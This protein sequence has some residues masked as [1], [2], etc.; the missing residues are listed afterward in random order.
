M[1]AIILA[2]G[3]GKRLG[4]LT[5]GNTKCMIEV[6][7]VTLIQRMLEQLDSLTPTLSHIVLVIGYEGKK[8][9]DYIATLNIKIPIHYVENKDFATTNNIFSLALAKEY[10]VSEDTLLLESDLIFE[11]GVLEELVNDPRPSLALVQKFEAWMDGSVVEIDS[12]DTML[13]LVPG[14]MFDYSLVSHYYKTVNIYKFSKDFSQYHYVPF[15]EAYSKAFGNNEYYEQVLRVIIMLD[16]SEVKAKRLEGYKWYE[17]DDIQDLDIA[18]SMFNISPDQRLEKIMKRYG[19]Y[20]RYPS[21]LD[22]C[23]LVNP[24]Y[25]PRRL[26]EEIKANFDRLIAEY[27]SGQDVNALLAAKYFDVRQEYM[28]V[29]NG[30][31]ELISS[32]LGFLEGPIGITKPTFEEYPNRLSEDRLEIFAPQTSDFSY[33][34]DDLI[35]YFSDKQISS[36]I[37]INPDNPSGNYLSKADVAK[38]LDWAKA[39]SIKLVLDESF[40]D[41]SDELENTY[42]ENELLKTNPPLI[43][44][45][46]ISKSFGVPGVRL[47]ILCCSDAELLA[48][49]RKGLAIWNIN[50]FGEFYLQIAEKYKGA[51]TSGLVAFRAER[52]RF[53]QELQNILGITVFP[54]QA[55]Y[56]M[57]E[58]TGKYRSREL[59]ETLLAQY[60]ILIKDLSEKIPLERQFA[61]FSIRCTEDNNALLAALKELMG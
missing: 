19:G 1:Q 53:V 44:V 15:L 58:L 39:K 7:G 34:A 54:S 38:L 24:Y 25:P 32:L 13:T 6:N 18:S 27:P 31:A 45:K 23:Y 21:L 59:A 9:Q 61:R 11:D 46:S 30:A 57:V 55:N 20:W 35:E 26:K 43:V 28:L 5:S 33:T 42:L 51:Y 49:V 52:K 48:R 56:V 3:M 8:L 29:G 41:F 50:S 10:L 17:I 47:G 37:L 16:S 14:K 40:S 2:A 12:D 36:L 60:N 22:F 4:D